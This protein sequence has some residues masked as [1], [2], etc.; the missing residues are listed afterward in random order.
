MVV[1]TVEQVSKQIK[2]GRIP[3]DWAVVR[4]GDHFD[5]KNG[6]NK[7]KNFFGY[8]TPIINYMD[9]YSHP[10]IKLID[11]KGKVSVSS[12]ERLAYEAKQGDVFFTRTSETVDEIGLSAVVVEKVNNTVFSGFLLRARPKTDFFDLQ[13]KKYCFRSSVVRKQIMSMSCETTRALTNGRSLSQVI[14]PVPKNKKEQSAIAE[15]LSD[16]DELIISLD[17]LVE[18]KKLIKQA[19]MQTLLTGKK[20]LP[21]FI[22]EWVIKKLSEIADIYNGGTPN[23]T[24]K[25]Y[26]NG[27]IFWCIPTDV[28]QTNGKYLFETE[29]K[30]TQ[31]GLSNSSVKLLPIGTLLLCSRATIGELKISKI[32]VT[33][34]Q[35]FKALVCFG[36]VDNEF[37][38]YKLL[39]IKNK[40]L[41]KSIG[42]TFLEIS[43][44]DTENIEILIPPTKEE[45]AAI[46][47]V[48]SDMDLEIEAL[49]QQRDKYKLLKAG[50]MQ[51]LLTGR[52]RLKWKS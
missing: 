25:E 37:V 26:W 47:K 39:T 52:I 24:V 41:E 32:E 7:A 51:Q 5:F 27:S 17:N 48:L 10:G 4:I 22:G 14:L 9:V 15:T 12:D 2:I 33:T 31:L 42:S 21:K 38:Y 40:L 30:I 50:L 36:Q 3:E 44:K 23:T 45:Q 34:N 18:K 43:K 19:A 49:E 20:R 35:G 1:L 46:A 16:I 13:F 11:I 29:R 28:T 8:G 6:L